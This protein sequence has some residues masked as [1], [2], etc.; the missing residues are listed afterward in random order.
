ML[1][2][3]QLVALACQQRQLAPGP[4]GALC[5]CNQAPKADDSVLWPGPE[6]LR[7]HWLSERAAATLPEGSG[8]ACNSTIDTS[9]AQSDCG[10]ALKL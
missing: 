4:F 3:R 7:C 9:A 5:Y 8:A 10:H 2:G 6:E 1:P